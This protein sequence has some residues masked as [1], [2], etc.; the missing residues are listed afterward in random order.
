[1]RNLVTRFAKN[2][3]GA[4]LVEYGML[5]GL[6]AVVCIGAVRIL[7]GTVNTVFTTINTPPRD[8]R[9]SQETCRYQSG[10]LGRLR[11]PGQ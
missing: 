8:R 6:I 3:E 2:D 7:G 11:H 1:M 9:A 4:A 10:K 5:V